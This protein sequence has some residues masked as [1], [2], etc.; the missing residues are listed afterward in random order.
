MVHKLS[1]QVEASSSYIH[2]TGTVMRAAVNVRVSNGFLR[3]WKSSV[4]REGC[5]SQQLIPLPQGANGFVCITGASTIHET[6]QSDQVAGWRK[7]Y[8]HLD[9]ESLVTAATLC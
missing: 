6:V 4:E 8:S 3:M 5:T 2:I 9:A 1:S 7:F